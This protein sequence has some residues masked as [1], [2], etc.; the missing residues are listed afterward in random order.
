DKPVYIRGGRQELLYGSERLISPLDWANTRRTFQGVKGFWH[1]EK[2]DVDAF[3]VQPV[4]DNTDLYHYGV[5]TKQNFEGLWATCRPK[6]G[7]AVDLYYLDLG[8]NNR[9]ARGQYGDLRG[10]NVSTFGARYVGDHQNF[11]WDGEG[12]YQFGSWA[13]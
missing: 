5:D 13:N 4:V 2:L 10:Y 3:W 12:M 11:L 1:S 7:Q 6:K 9:I 8:N